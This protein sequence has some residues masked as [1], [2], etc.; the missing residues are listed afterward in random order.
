VEEPIPV[1]F[2]L[3]VV[4]P[5]GWEPPGGHGRVMSKLMGLVRPRERR[6]ERIGI[7][8][9]CGEPITRDGKPLMAERG[10][11]V[12]SHV[13]NPDKRYELAHRSACAQVAAGVDALVVFHSGRLTRDMND[14]LWWCDWLGVPWRVIRL[15]PAPEPL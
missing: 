4:A 15:D 2:H 12:S 10:W 1:W 7:T 6:K 8:G 5:P 13:R 14:L 3:G 9:V 11:H